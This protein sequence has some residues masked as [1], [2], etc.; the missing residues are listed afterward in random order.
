VL[1]SMTAAVEM[2]ALNGKVYESITKYL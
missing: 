2:T 1:N